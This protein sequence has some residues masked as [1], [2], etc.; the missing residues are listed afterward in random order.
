M[1]ETWAHLAILLRMSCLKGDFSNPKGPVGLQWDPKLG[2]QTLRTQMLSHC[3]TTTINTAQ[4]SL[5]PKEL[6]HHTQGLLKPALL[7][8]LLCP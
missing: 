7:C 5:C 3:Y 2:L 8:T 4:G 1:I 6:L